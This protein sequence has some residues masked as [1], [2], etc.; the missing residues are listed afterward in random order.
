MVASRFSS[1]RATG[2]RPKMSRG[3]TERTQRTIHHTDVIACLFSKGSDST[4][5]RGPLILLAF[6]MKGKTPPSY[7]PVSPDAG[8]RK[9]LD[10]PPR[11]PNSQ[12]IEHQADSK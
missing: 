8:D 2:S 11:I 6:Q 12:S 4:E 5:P 1:A 3:Y 9:D 10:P 7:Q